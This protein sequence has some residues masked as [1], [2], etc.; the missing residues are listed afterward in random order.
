MDSEDSDK[1]KLAT[2]GGGCF[3]YLY[4]VFI[5]VKGVIK[6]ESGYSGDIAENANYK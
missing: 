1:Y 5:R 3:W 4:A 6:V 2:F